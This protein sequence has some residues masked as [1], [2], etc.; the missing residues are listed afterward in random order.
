MKLPPT[1][2]SGFGRY[3]VMMVPKRASDHGIVM[4]FIT[5]L[6]VDRRSNISDF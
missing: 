4:E 6:E 5:V 3:D 2:E 1:R